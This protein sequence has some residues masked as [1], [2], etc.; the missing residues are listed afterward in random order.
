[1]S[2]APSDA[3]IPTIVA[4]TRAR[5]SNGLTIIV[6]ADSRYREVLLNWL[7]ALSLNRID[8]YL[9][10]AL[11]EPL[12]AWLG[13]HDIAS[14]LSPV[15]AGLSALWYRR[16][17][18]FSALCAAGIDFVHSDADAIWLRDPSADYFSEPDTELVI[19]Q[20][21]V[22]PRDVHQRFGF[23]L[24]C[25]LFRLR[26]TPRTQR[27]LSQLE[28]DVL[29]TG[30][31]QVS[32]NRLVLN[33]S[34]SWRIERADAYQLEGQ[35]LEFLCS[36]S[37]MRGL[38]SDGLSVSVLPHHLFRRVPVTAAET[39]YVMHLLTPKDPVAKMNAF[40]GYGSLLLRPDWE[41]IPFHAGTLA[42]LRRND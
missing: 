4:A 19:S 32:L 6:F 27:L 5:A 22:W 13:R 40:A 15:S 23:V 28:A 38:S 11:D 34:S 24:C 29:A 2:R 12:Y 26:S 1:M 14:V 8:N 31:D 41:R 7:V 39:P 35:G 9:V 17:Q 10:V 20:G 30:D 36:R 37:A 3:A 18:I 16:V 25:G 33:H 42:S 21:T